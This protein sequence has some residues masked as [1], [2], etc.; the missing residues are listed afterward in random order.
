MKLSNRVQRELPCM[1]ASPRRHGLLV[2]H[3]GRHGILVKKE[4]HRSPKQHRLLPLPLIP[5]DNVVRHLLK[6]PRTVCGT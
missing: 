3:S 5:G 2:S 4:M 6:A 1:D